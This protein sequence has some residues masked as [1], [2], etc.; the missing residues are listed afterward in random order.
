MLTILGS[1]SLLLTLSYQGYFKDLNQNS[2][3][4]KQAEQS[5][6]EEL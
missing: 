4:H 6:T 5:G 2:D 3:K 1:A